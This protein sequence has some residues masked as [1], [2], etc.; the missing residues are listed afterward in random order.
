M[1]AT[2]MDAPRNV[3]FMGAEKSEQM[4][5]ARYDNEKPNEVVQNILSRLS[6][7]QF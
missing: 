6:L 7:A 1:I 4:H 2:R 3:D 5:L